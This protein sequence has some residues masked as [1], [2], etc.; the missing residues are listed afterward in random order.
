LAAADW[1]EGVELAFNN[2]SEA[3][4]ADVVGTAVAAGAGAWGE[5]GELLLLLEAKN[6][7]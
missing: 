2:E 1:P 7:G 3:A 4:A 5:G 6:L